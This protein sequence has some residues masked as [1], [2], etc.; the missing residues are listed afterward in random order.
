MTERT[1]PAE[2]LE[3]EEK[4]SRIKPEGKELG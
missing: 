2:K 4:V 3:Q 1:G